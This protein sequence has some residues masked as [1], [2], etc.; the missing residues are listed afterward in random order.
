[1]AYS[2]FYSQWFDADY[3]ANGNLESPSTTP[4]TAAAAEAW[5]GALAD[6]LPQ[7]V[8]GDLVGYDGTN[9]DRLPVGT[10]TAALVADS[11]QALGVRWSTTTYVP[12]TQR[13]PLGG[14]VTLTYA[15]TV[16]PN[17]ADANAQRITATGNLTLGAPTNPA[18]GQ[19]LMVEVVADGAN[20]TVTLDTPIVLTTG[21]TR[22]YTITSAQ[23][24]FLGL[25][26]SA[27]L[28][29]WILLAQTQTI[30]G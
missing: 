6:A 17:A 10:N 2:P 12:A 18:S 16:T 24:G 19:S 25:R 23:R 8:K 28:G 20:R 1:V 14:A 30:A 3:D 27:N 22:A 26:Y 13:A 21:T 5:D 15:A 9:T 4:F 11:T 7:T 29:A